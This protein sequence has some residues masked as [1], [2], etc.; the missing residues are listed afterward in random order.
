MSKSK[1]VRAAR[2]R[3]LL[4]RRKPR[5]KVVFTN[6]CFD[7]MHA[8]HVRYLRKARALGDV[9]VVGVNTDA[10]VRKLKG[11][12]R[13]LVPLAQR[14][15]VLGALECVD[16]LIAFAEDTPERLITR[17]DPDVLVKGADYKQHQIAGAARVKAR[18]GSVRRIALVQGLS[19]S[20]LVQK[21]KES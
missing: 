15:E 21:I 5:P 17:V 7:L 3:V 9:L 14:L 19:T 11:P 1:I 4:S 20:K 6:G 16:Y 18:G 10:S 13:P 12:K 2:L 8:G